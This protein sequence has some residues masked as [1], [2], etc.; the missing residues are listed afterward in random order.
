VGRFALV[1]TAPWSLSVEE[2]FPITNRGTAVTGHLDGDPP[3]A[4]MSGWIEANGNSV[5]VERI[6]VEVLTGDGHEAVALLLHGV[7]REAVPVGSV[8]RF[9]LR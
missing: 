1:T 2:A 8:I 9:R 3:F 5:A 7:K 6:T 4:D